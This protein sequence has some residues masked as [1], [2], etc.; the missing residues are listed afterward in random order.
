MKTG[1]SKKKTLDAQFEGSS[2]N[3]ALPIFYDIDI[4]NEFYD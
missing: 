4:Q 3:L 1:R 2:L